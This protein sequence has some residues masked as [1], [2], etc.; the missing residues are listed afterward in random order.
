[1][2]V[3]GNEPITKVEASRNGGAYVL[4][5]K[6]S[7]GTWAKSINAPNGTSVVFRATGASGATAT[8]SPVIWT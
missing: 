1:M 5:D 7:W 4:L 8:S 3:S 2:A 6:Q